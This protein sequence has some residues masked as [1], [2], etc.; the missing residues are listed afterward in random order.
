MCNVG[1]VIE[2]GGIDDNFHIGD[3]VASN[4]PHAGVVFINS[5]KNS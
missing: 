5:C 2:V 1:E 4:G 3:R